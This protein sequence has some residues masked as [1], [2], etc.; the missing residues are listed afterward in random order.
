MTRT[1]LVVPFVLMAACLGTSPEEELAASLGP[2][3]DLRG[4]DDDDEG[5]E[6]HRY[7][8]PCLVCHGERLRRGGE[9][10]AVAG[11][12][13]LRATDP[14]G[15]QGATVSVV[16]DAGRAFTVRSNRSGNFMVKVDRGRDAPRDRGD[17]EVA[18]PWEPLFP[19]ETSVSL[20]GTEQ[21]METL[22]HREGSCAGCHDLDA[23]ASSVGRIYVLEEP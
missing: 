7:G 10:F 3:Y 6:T 23:G 9:V 8:Q 12:V 17:G 5:S 21:V 19:L 11:T 22:V 14:V 20:D 15:V 1:P 4:D 16:D 2:D 18:I 13:Y